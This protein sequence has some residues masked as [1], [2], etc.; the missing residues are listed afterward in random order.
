M[1]EQKKSKSF[2]KS[3]DQPLLCLAMIVKDG[4]RIFTE[5][6][7]EALPWVDE[8]VIGDTG[9]SDKSPDEAKARGA[10]VIQIPWQKDF[11]KARNTVL[12]QCT[13]QW[14]L[15][16]DADERISPDGWQ[17]LRRWVQERSVCRE[18][19]A[20]RLETRN[21]TQGRYSK[22]GW[23]PVPNP[24]PDA[25]PQG[26]PASGY[27]PSLKIRLFPNL[28]AIRFSGCLHE[29]VEAG[30]VATGLPA[31]DLLVPI[32]HFGLLQN[33]PGKSRRYLDLA[34]KKASEEP[35]SAKTWSELA[36]CATS[37][38]QYD[39]ALAALDRAL[40][41][42]PG[43]INRRLTA[44]WLLKE[45]GSLE[46]AD[47]QLNAV[48]GS[49]GINDA[50]LA[51]ACHLRAQIALMSDSLERVPHLL[52]VAIRLSP[53][54]GLIM[55]TLGVWHLKEGRG[56]TARMALEKARTLLPG[57]ADPLLNLAV[58]HEASKQPLLARDCA[59]QALRLAPDSAKAKEILSR[60]EKAVTSTQ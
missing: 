31:V 46:Q 49:A 40:V 58:L 41:L 32:H 34:R 52:S 16:L 38:G 59:R 60:L 14:V 3:G 21:Y 9:S 53:D 29:T 35:H 47:L 17:I 57:N 24:D 26:N 33:N 30:V 55:N 15:I 13:G 7:D 19:V 51:E 10:R 25:L 8:I 5:L 39:E 11:S 12:D 28:D 56:D 54:N 44:G 1:S 50:Q 36:D 27:V 43:N 20:A 45:T 4:G 22:R 37:C 42:E 48:I 23:C 6:L 18:Q 2:K